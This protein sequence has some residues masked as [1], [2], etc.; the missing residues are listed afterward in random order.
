MENEDL[1]RKF[2]ALEAEVFARTDA[3][4]TAFV[5]AEGATVV[6]WKEGAPFLAAIGLISFV[7]QKLMAAWNLE[8]PENLQVNRTYETH[9][10]PPIPPELEPN[11]DVPPIDK[12]D[13]TLEWES[14]RDI[15]DEMMT[16]FPHTVIT[17]L[18]KGKQGEIYDWASFR[19]NPIM[20]MGLTRWA[21]WR[22]RHSLYGVMSEGKPKDY[23]LI[24][25]IRETDQEGVFKAWWR[26][27]S[28]YMSM[29]L[30]TI[31]GDV[32]YQQMEAT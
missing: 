21:C 27:E 17:S 6:N 29:G 12:P 10:S 14:T 13:D 32:I 7:E 11:P 20:L 26:K 19:G 4:M 22:L 25:G 31:V 18:Y 23:D 30:A 24:L 16:I 9:L 5:T 1:Y 8:Q 15:R 28:P 3:T 2:S